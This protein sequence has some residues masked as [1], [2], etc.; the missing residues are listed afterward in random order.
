MSEEKERKVPSIKIHPLYV[1]SITRQT[2]VFG[3]WLDPGKVMDAPLIAWYIEGSDKRILV[4]TG[5][6]DPSKIPP[7]LNPYKRE[8]DQSIENALKK[9]GVNCE[10]IDIV[11][12]THLHWDHSAGNGLFPRAKIIIQEEELR[13]ARSPFPINVHGYIK[14][15]VEDIDYTVISGDKRIARGV[16][17]IFT[18]GHTYG[19]QGVMVEASER[20]YLIAGDTFGLFRNLESNPPLISGIYVDL[21][22]YYET[23][24]KISKLSAFILPGHDFKVFERKIYS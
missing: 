4:D 10:D 8:N 12:A 19:M 17:V 14:S 22:K 23:L 7:R 9:I 11:I 13:S 2:M 15:I 3:Y 6:G 5:G 1:G 16:E 24:E 21:R 18:P 20:S